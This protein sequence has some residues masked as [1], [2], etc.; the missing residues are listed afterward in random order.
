MIYRVYVIDIIDFDVFD[1]YGAGL[2]RFL[3][4]GQLIVELLGICVFINFEFMCTCEIVVICVRIF[5]T[6][7]LSFVNG[8]A[9]RDFTG[10]DFTVGRV[11]GLGLFIRACVFEIRVR[12]DALF[13]GDFLFDD[14][15]IFDDSEDFREYRMRLFLITNDHYDSEALSYLFRFCYRR[16][17]VSIMLGQLGQTI[18]LGVDANDLNRGVFEYSTVG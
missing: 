9:N 16:I 6:I 13:I 12:L 2:R 14:Y 15:V 1:I 7:I 18:D 10:I 11:Q 3:R 4:V 8:L 5:F 17:L